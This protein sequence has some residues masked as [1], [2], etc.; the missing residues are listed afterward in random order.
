MI[1]F[2]QIRFPEKGAHT[3]GF[4]VS[5]TI[6]R[7]NEI[8]Y[9]CH[10]PK[11]VPKFVSLFGDLTGLS[12]INDETSKGTISLRDDIHGLFRSASINIVLLKISY[13]FNI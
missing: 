6:A 3:L 7:K 10:V 12:G 8:S 9:S 4:Q 11:G 2:S 1:P 5:R 13:W